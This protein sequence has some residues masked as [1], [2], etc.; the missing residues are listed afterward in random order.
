MVS[1]NDYGLGVGH[2]LLAQLQIH[3]QR[4]F[5]C[6]EDRVCVN[7]LFLLRPALC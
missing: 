6:V 3:F 4:M 2:R 7:L 5:P 1:C